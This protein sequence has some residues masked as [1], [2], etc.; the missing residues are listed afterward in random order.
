[1]ITGTHSIIYSSNADADRT[2]FHD[3]LQF[4]AVDVGDGWLIFSLP[5]AELAV[6][7]AVKNNAHELFLMCEDI[8]EIRENLS[9]QNVPCSEVEKLSWGSLIR[10]TLPGGGSLGI[11]QPRHETPPAV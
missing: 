11:Y 10:I 9:G 7:P 4:P 3:L 1:M 8:N 5:P 6:H 2:F